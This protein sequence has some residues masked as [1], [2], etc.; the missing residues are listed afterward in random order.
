MDEALEREG[1]ELVSCSTPQF[2]ISGRAGRFA[3]LQASSPVEGKKGQA[4]VQGQ[5]WAL[6]ISFL[7]FGSDCSILLFP[8]TLKQGL[9]K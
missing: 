7:H 3:S 5:P 4:Q 9:C 1:K 8:S 2:I 6:W